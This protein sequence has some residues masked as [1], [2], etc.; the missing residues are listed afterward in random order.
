MLNTDIPTTAAQRE[1]T[2]ELEMK[3]RRARLAASQWSPAQLDAEKMA[4][5]AS[6]ELYIES[7]AI[8][9]AANAMPEICEVAAAITCEPLC[10]TNRSF[11]RI[12]IPQQAQQ[13]PPKDRAVEATQSDML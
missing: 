4:G 9:A 5:R 3:K 11:T 13:E 12:A 10:S 7:C 2:C 6:M 8:R 1:P